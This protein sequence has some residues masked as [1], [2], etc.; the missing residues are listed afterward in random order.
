M[1]G[2]KNNRVHG[3]N[4][5]GFLLYYTCN[6]K[7]NNMAEEKDK[8]KTQEEKDKEVLASWWEGEHWSD[9]AK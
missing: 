4:D 8:E 1:T 6:N 3:L 9:K 2:Y 5:H 7:E